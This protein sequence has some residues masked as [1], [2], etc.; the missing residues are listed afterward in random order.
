MVL[1]TGRVIIMKGGISALGAR[2]IAREI[3]Y[4]VGTLYN[5]FE[6]FDDIILQINGETL[7]E[8]NRQFENKFS[9]GKDTVSTILN[10]TDIYLD[11]IDQNLRLWQ[12]IFEYNWREGQRDLPAWYQEKIDRLF[13]WVENALEDLTGSDSLSGSRSARV[14]WAGVH[15]ICILN[16]TGKLAHVDQD[17]ARDMVRTLV[18]NFLH[19]LN[20]SKN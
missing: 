5:I 19:G 11:F 16:L 7:D 14:L 4:T 1:A 6:D 17:S 18:I 12:T 15:G 9:P 10:L 8:L 2:R 3:G 13:A 20:A